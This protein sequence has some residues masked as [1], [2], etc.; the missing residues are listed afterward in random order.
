MIDTYKV[1]NAIYLLTV[2]F[3]PE[4]IGWRTESYG[5]WRE[6]SKEWKNYYSK[7]NRQKLAELVLEDFAIKYKG[8]KIDP[9][10][11]TGYEKDL[12][13]FKNNLINEVNAYRYKTINKNTFFNTKRLYSCV[14]NFEDIGFG[15]CL[16][17]HAYVT[18]EKVTKEEMIMI[19]ETFCCCFSTIAERLNK[20][21]VR[22]KELEALGLPVTLTE[23][24]KVIESSGDLGELFSWNKTQE[25][26]LFWA[27]LFLD[28]KEGFRLEVNQYLNYL[29][30]ELKLPVVK[31]KKV[32]ER[33]IKT[34]KLAT[35]TTATIATNTTATIAWQNTTF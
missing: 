22:V 12:E 3:N 23:L 19:I 11:F 29:H 35:N 13:K 33:N 15:R 24:K 16:L 26:F 5:K 34:F 9:S 25:G 30:P 4:E 17:D 1:S 20:K 8:S 7:E 32:D 31:E 28:N 18:P 6:I 27:K 14:E 2:V 10:C 21:E